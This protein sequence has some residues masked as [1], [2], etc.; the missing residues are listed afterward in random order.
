MKKRILTYKYRGQIAERNISERQTLDNK[1]LVT[2]SFILRKCFQNKTRN[3]KWMCTQGTVQR[4][5]FWSK[6]HVSSEIKSKC[7]LKQCEE[8][9][10]DVNIG[11][12]WFRTLCRLSKLVVTNFSF[13]QKKIKHGFNCLGIVRQSYMK[14]KTLLY[15]EIAPPSYTGVAWY[16]EI[17]LWGQNSR[18]RTM[19]YW[20]LDGE[21]FSCFFLKKEFVKR[22]L[23]I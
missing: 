16:N 19:L 7:Y 9:R 11:N 4:K 12:I 8:F 14:K 15:N 20:V 1:S 3:A 22:G 5:I 18:S 10:N 2:R 21:Y 17:L 13:S 23:F 6:I